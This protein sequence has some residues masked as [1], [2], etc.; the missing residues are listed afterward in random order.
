MTS[1]RRRRRPG[2]GRTLLALAATFA[3]AAGCHQLP[4]GPPSILSPSRP[5]RASAKLTSAQTSDVQVAMGRSMENQND[6]DGAIA[7]YQAALRMDPKRVDAVARLAV[8]SDRKG[9]F[10][11]SGPLYDRALKVAPDDPELLCD[12][13]YSLY[14]QG[15]LKEAEPFLRRSI[16]LK[17]DLL[18][19]HN[20]LGLVLGRTGRPDEAVAEFSKAGA[21]EADARLNLAFALAIEHRWDLAR[22]QYALALAA[23]PASGRARA[24]LRELDLIAARQGR[25]ARTRDAE[26]LTVGAESPLPELPR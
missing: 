10:K 5:D 2:R 6:P 9:D 26:V 18:R 8:L 16:A 11:A 14:L 3:P 7:A 23:E 20:N 17:A 12:R 13:G 15:K 4:Q 19:A 22:T 1:S 24:G 25:S 21:S